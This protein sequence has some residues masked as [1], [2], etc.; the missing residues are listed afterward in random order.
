KPISK[1]PAC[2][3]ENREPVEL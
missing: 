2:G 1:C 3:S